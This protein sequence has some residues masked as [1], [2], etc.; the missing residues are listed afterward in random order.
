M[1]G[2]SKKMPPGKPRSWWDDQV[3]EHARR[4]S[5]PQGISGKTTR[6]GYPLPQFNPDPMQSPAVQK[7]VAD[8]RRKWAAEAAAMERRRAETAAAERLI[9]YNRLTDALGKAWAAPFTLA[10]SVAGAANVGIAR[11]MGDKRASISVRDNGIQF[12]HGH[13]GDP[14]QAFTL[15]NAVLHG[16]ESQASYPNKRYDGE[17]TNAT[18]SEHESG[19]TYRYQHPGFVADYIRYLVREKLTGKP[20][21]YEREADDFGDWKSHRRGGGR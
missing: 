15:G 17:G 10:G 12:E 18:T 13:F 3:L 1:T 20:N 5:A 21:P 4:Q 11:A 16:P 19:H 9:P 2:F 6:G 8:H 14:D 7:I